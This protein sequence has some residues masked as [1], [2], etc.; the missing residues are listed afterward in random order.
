MDHCS[1]GCQEF[2]FVGGSQQISE[3]LADKIGRSRVLLEHPV[4]KLEYTPTAEDGVPGSSAVQSCLPSSGLLF[5]LLTAEV[6]VTTRDGTVVKAKFAVLALPPNL[7]GRIEFQ[8]LLPAPRMW[9]TQAAPQG[10][11]I[12]VLMVFKEAWWREGGMNGCI[13]CDVYGSG[14]L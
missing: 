12:K 7:Y 4:R 14:I 9:L 10:N 5:E 2:K 13:F 3:R 8:P 1:E 11:V 6:T